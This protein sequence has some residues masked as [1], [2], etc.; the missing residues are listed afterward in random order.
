MNILFIG[1]IGVYHALVAARLFMGIDNRRELL[2]MPELGNHTMEDSGNPIYAGK[3]QRGNSVYCLGVGADVPMVKKT[4]AQFLEILGFS[5]QDLI[6]KTI[7]AKNER[8][9]FKLYQLS[10]L[11]GFHTIGH[12]CIVWDLTNRLSMLEQAVKTFQAELQNLEDLAC[13]AALIANEREHQ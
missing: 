7:Q 6:V 8:M 13:G 12:T 5:N 3:D 1:T 10:K 4:I 9:I 2:S 11:P